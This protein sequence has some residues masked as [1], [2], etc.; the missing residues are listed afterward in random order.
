MNEHTLAIEK[1]PI[2][3]TDAEFTHDVLFKMRSRQ[4]TSTNTALHNS[5]VI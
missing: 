3:A 1:R 2:N 4:F 5:C